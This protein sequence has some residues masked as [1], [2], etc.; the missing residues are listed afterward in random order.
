MPQFSSI[1]VYGREPNLLQSRRWVFE[2]GGF[3]VASAATLAE[4]QQMTAGQHF[5]LLVLCHTLSQQESH[6]ALAW[7][8][9]LPAMRRLSLVTGA[10]SG[11]DLAHE[12]VLSQFAGPRELVSAA[13]RVLAA[14][15]SIASFVVASGVAADRRSAGPLTGATR[16]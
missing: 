11:G 7:A 14:P 2:V 16:G 4:A 6:D 8:R 3:Q 13:Q 12:A 15:A 5:D 9:T 1:L 10:V